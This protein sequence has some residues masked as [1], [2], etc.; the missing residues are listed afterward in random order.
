MNCQNKTFT[1]RNS[2]IQ[3]CRGNREQA[4]R[5]V[6]NESDDPM[7]IHEQPS[8]GLARLV[9]AADLLRWLTGP[10]VSCLDGRVRATATDRT[11]PGARYPSRTEVASADGQNRHPTEA[12]RSP[13]SL[14][15][16]GPSPFRTPAGTTGDGIAA[17]SP[18]ARAPA[19]P[20]RTRSPRR[21][22]VRTRP[23]R[24]RPPRRAR[25]APIPSPR[26]ISKSNKRTI[27][28]NRI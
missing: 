16:R 20:G 19:V 24:T 27:R 6:T 28:D 8:V 3:C 22:S 17:D 25:L 1:E 2:N 26:T 12:P 18:L 9:R 7:S 23:E 21:S 13:S 14:T 11:C 15:R 5:G 4:P 10:T